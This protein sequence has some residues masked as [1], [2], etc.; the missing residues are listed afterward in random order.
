MESKRS[1]ENESTDLQ[2]VLEGDHNDSQLEQTSQPNERDDSFNMNS[3]RESI[4]EIESNINPNIEQISE[5]EPT[6]GPNEEQ[7]YEDQ[8]SV[9]Q[10]EDSFE[11][12]ITINHWCDLCKK[13]IA[14]DVI[15]SHL[16]ECTSEPYNEDV[17]KADGGECPICL[18]QLK[19]EET[20]ARL[21]CLCIYHINCIK[22][23]FR[24]VKGCP[25]HQ[26]H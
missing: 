2:S 15:E 13:V 3:I 24:F 12:E 16:I 25:Q 7:I 20:V 9:E 4:A 5:E 18:D 22:G 1:A 23:W 17:L 8:N 11:E 14:F 6:E 26:I 10:F 19:A 21:P